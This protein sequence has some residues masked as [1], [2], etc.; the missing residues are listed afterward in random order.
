[1]VRAVIV[2]LWM[3]P[4]MSVRDGYME[5]HSP[6]I[7]EPVWIMHT[8]RISPAAVGQQRRRMMQVRPPKCGEC[9]AETVGINRVTVRRTLLDEQP[10]DNTGWTHEGSDDACFT[11][12]CGC[13]T[14]AGTQSKA[15]NMHNKV[16]AVASTDASHTTASGYCAQGSGHVPANQGC[17]SLD[18]TGELGKHPKSTEINCMTRNVSFDR[19][20]TLTA[21]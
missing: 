18:D 21:V 16:S 11:A 20:A 12:C 9:I 19:A 2:L 10:M 15:A 13:A 8:R 6:V 1:M 4:C 7:L 5:D 14:D 17:A 3:P